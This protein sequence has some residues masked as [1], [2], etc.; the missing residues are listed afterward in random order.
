MGIVLQTCE[1]IVRDECTM[2]NKK[3]MEALGHTLKDLRENRQLFN[4]TLILLS[5]DFRQTL[6]VIPHLKTAGELNACLSSIAICK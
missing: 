1:L 2:T 5:R 6:L 4:G 3:A